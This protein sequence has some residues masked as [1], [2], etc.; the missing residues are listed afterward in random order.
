MK[1]ITLS[2]DEETL[3]AGREYAKKHHLSLN[4]L[5]RKLLK[6]TVVPSSTQWLS[7]AFML[8]DRAG[9]DS[10]GVTWKRGELH[11]V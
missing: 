8:M 10:R 4:A 5:M 9:A 1:N 6:Q 7:E 11:R 2:I 3:R